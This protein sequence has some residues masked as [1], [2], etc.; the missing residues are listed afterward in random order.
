MLLRK[1]MKEA[2]F[3]EQQIIEILKPAETGTKVAGLCPE[4]GSEARRRLFL[5]CWVRWRITT[6]CGG[7][8]V[9]QQPGQK[10]CRLDRYSSRSGK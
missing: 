7:A 6:R 4:L 1:E 2:R 9:A 5:K 8:A 3:S 10:S